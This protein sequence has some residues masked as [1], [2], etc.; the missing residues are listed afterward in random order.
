MLSDGNRKGFFRR[1]YGSYFPFR[2]DRPFGKHIRLAFHLAVFINVLQ[3]AEQ[4]V[5]GII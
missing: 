2:S 1:I 5:R 3:R 4:I